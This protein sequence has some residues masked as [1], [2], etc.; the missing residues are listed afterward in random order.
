MMPSRLSGKRPDLMSKEHAE[1]ASLKLAE[2]NEKWTLASGDKKHDA[3]DAPS[4]PKVD[5]AGAR[6]RMVPAQAP[7]RS[8]TMGFCEQLFSAVLCCRSAKLPDFLAVRLPPLPRF[9]QLVSKGYSFSHRSP[10]K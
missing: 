5:R 2:T 3:G 6:R 10:G 9:K 1:H 7:G 4:R 8:R